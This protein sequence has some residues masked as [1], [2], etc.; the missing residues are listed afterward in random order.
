MRI[1]K[2]IIGI[3]NALMDVVVKLTDDAILQR[4]N[5]P[6]GSMTLVDAATSASINRQTEGLEKILAPGGSV[7]NTID[8]LAHLG[9]N[10]AFIGKVGNDGMGTSYRDGLTKIGAKPILFKSANPTGVAMALVSPDSER[11]FGTYLGAAVELSPDD[12]SPELF[13]GYDIVYIE[14]YLVQNHD[15]I[16]KA[17]AL[18]NDA[19]LTIALDLASYN[20]VE[21]NLGFL[22]EILSEYVDIVFANEEEAKSFTGN[23]PM[24]AAL[25]LGSLCEI[26]VVKTGAK[27]SLICFEDEIIEI[28]VT[29]TTCIDTTGA[30][31]LYSAGFLYGYSYGLPLE[32]CGKLASIVAGKVIT[33]YGARMDEGMWKEIKEEVN[34]VISKFD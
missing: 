33:I 3:G 17:A 5:L 23:A 25:E 1:A 22:E 7:A 6:K 28:G 13:V 2:S 12:L 29:G 14:G 15:L 27:G 10:A 9:A 16:S 20:V 19:G 11:T 21:E 4:D 31:D 18:A 8:G 26:A 24:E 30:G 32:T 34:G